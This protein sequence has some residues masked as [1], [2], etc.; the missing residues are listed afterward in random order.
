LHLLPN[1]DNIYV[2]ILNGLFSNNQSNIISISGPNQIQIHIEKCDLSVSRLILFAEYINNNAQRFNWIHLYDISLTDMIDIN[3]LKSIYFDQYC[4]GLWIY[5]LQL[6][7]TQSTEC[8]NT[9]II[10]LSILQLFAGIKQLILTL[11]RNDE[12]N[13]NSYS[14]Q[15]SIEYS[16]NMTNLTRLRLYTN[17]DTTSIGKTYWTCINSILQKCPNIRM[18]EIGHYSKISI[19]EPIDLHFLSLKHDIELDI[20]N[21]IFTDND[22]N[23]ICIN[24]EVK[25]INIEFNQCKYSYRRLISFANYINQNSQLFNE[26]EFIGVYNKDIPLFNAVLMNTEF[27]HFAIEQYGSYYSIVKWLKI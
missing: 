11:P 10:N 14:L 15:Q 27:D 9:Y 26:I 5:N 12:M 3:K 21:I 16:S 4:G 6:D 22:S 18:I 20:S 7:S 23:M 17:D 8:L 19:D 2:N 25:Q 24:G 1:I 13:D